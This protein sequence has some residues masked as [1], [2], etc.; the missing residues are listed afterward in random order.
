M[1]MAAEQFR[2][3]IYHNELEHKVQAFSNAI[4]SSSKG[5]IQLSHWPGKNVEA[6]ATPFFAECDFRH[7]CVQTPPIQNIAVDDIWLENGMSFLKLNA[8][9]GEAEALRGSRKLLSTRNVCVVMMYVRKLLRG[10]D[11]SH[12]RFTS[13]VYDLLQLGG[14]HTEWLRV[15]ASDPKIHKLTELQDVANFEA[16]FSRGDLMM[17]DFLISSNKESRCDSITR[18]LPRAIGYLA[19]E[20]ITILT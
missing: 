13:D 6:R 8:N 9:G 7:G 2:R 19:H 12:E 11:P 17:T 5:S 1:P 14:L 18:H 15:H 16:L 3:A 4:S 10:R 20:D